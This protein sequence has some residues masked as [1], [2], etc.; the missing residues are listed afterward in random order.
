M[1]ETLTDQ[2]KAIL[3]IIQVELQQFRIQHLTEKQPFKQTMRIYKR[4]NEGENP[5]FL[6]DEEQEFNAFVKE[7]LLLPTM[8]PPFELMEKNFLPAKSPLKTDGNKLYYPYF[9]IVYEGYSVT[10][11]VCFVHVMGG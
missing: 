9:A 1:V 10:Q 2:E 11:L 3:D 4:I 7:R 6:P 5:F 8:N